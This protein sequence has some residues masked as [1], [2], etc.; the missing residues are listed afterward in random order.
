RRLRPGDRPQPARRHRAAVRP[1]TGGGACQPGS[2]R[3]PARGA[4][5]G[6]GGRAEIL[7][8]QDSVIPGPGGGQEKVAVL[9][10]PQGI[11]GRYVKTRLV[12]FGEYIPF[13][14]QLSWLTKISKAR[15]SNMT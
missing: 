11:Q 15:S 4:A 13:K 3:P 8:S 6:R 7:V 10:S 14:Q 12:P 1:G 9:V 5:G 2:P